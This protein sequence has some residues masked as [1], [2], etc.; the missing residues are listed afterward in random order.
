MAHGSPSRQFCK[1]CKHYGL[2]SRFS[3]R[4]CPKCGS[5]TVKADENLIKKLSGL[6][7]FQTINF[8][9]NWKKASKD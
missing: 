8:N 7:N 2:V 3:L 6:L 1:Q 9:F 4:L 5:K